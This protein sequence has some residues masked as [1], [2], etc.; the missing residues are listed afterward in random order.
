MFAGCTEITM[1]LSC[2]KYPAARYLHQEWLNNVNSLLAF[3]ESVHMGVKGVIRSSGAGLE[4]VR[5]TVKG[6]NFTV[7][8]SARGEYWRL[9]LPGSYTLEFR[10]DGYEPLTKDVLVKDQ[11]LR[12]DVEM[13]KAMPPK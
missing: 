5:V 10:K 4:G 13:T 2:C 6:V 11:V 7:T 8:S 1:E 9:L 12:L 3:M